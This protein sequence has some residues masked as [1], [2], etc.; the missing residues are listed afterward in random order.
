MLVVDQ[1]EQVFTQCADESERRAFITAL[2]AAATTGHGQR[3]VPAAMVILAVRAD[4]EARCADYEELAD[5]VQGRYLLRPMTDRQLRLAI[6]EP[7]RMARA[8]VDGAL[9]DELVRA[10]RTSPPT[11]A[12]AAQAGPGYFP[13]CLTR[14]TRRGAAAT[15]DVLTLADYERVGGIE[16]S[17]GACADAAFTSLS[18]RPQ[19]VARE[20]FTRLTV[21]SADGADTAG[22]SRPGS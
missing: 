22:R 5:A 21:T 13:T 8:S 2:H 3:Q 16:G 12:G 17:I 20:V 7:A 6:T 14:W 1:F 9:V 18:P 19:E 11:A 10:I 15:G 4:F